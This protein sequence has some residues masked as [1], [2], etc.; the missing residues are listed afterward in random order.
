MRGAVTCDRPRCQH[1]SCRYE[2]T[3]AVTLCANE[4]YRALPPAQGRRPRY[5]RWHATVTAALK[6]AELGPPAETEE[7]TR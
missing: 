4:R 1:G 3:P 2:A 5:C 6:N 7:H